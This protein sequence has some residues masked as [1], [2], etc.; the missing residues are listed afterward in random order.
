[1]PDVDVE[2]DAGDPVAETLTGR[3]HAMLSTALTRQHD[4]PFGNPVLAVALAIAREIEDGSI[5][6]ASIAEA[7]RVLRDD[8]FRRRAG[9]LAAYV[10]LRAGGDTDAG[11]ARFRR[12]AERCVRPDPHDSPVPLAR[13]REAV[14][15]IRFGAVFTA[16][17]TFAASPEVYAAL[18][19]LATGDRDDTPF[20]E[21]HRPGRI[22]L[23]EEFGQAFAAIERGR[24]AIDRLTTE[25]F[26][27]AAHVWPNS[28][29]EISPRP[30][31][32]T[33]W[34][35]YDTDG[36]TDIGWHDTLRLRLR[37]KRA[38]LERLSAQLEP[39]SGT[40]A[41][42]AR[43][44]AAIGAVSDQID[45]CPTGN[46][47][48]EV[49]RFA[50]ALVDRREEALLSPADLGPLL[51]DAEANAAP[52][53]V[54]PLLVA[55]AGLRS[56]GLSLSHTHMRLNATQI[57]NVARQRLGFTDAPED[58]SRR[59]ALLAQINEVLDETRPVPFDL[60][61]LIAE[62]AS[63]ARLMM[64]A[65]TI[66]KH[67]DQ[68]TP[69]RFLIAETES[70]YTLLCALWLAR[71]LGIERQIEISPLFETAEAL[72]RG[73]RVVDEAL[74][75]PHYQDYVRATGRL[76]LQF[77]YSDSGRYVGQMAAT[78]QI[79]RLR[80]KIA[81]L[82][83]TRGL[84]GIEV[85]LFDTHGESIGRGAH[86]G[87][88]ADR[89]AYLSPAW[90]RANFAR[91][92]VAIREE[93]AFQGGDGYALFG[94]PGLAVAT[95]ATIAE[96][97]FAA[98]ETGHDP[99]YEDP[100]FSADFFATIAGSMQA[101]VDDPG[102]AALLGAFGPALIDKTGSRPAARQSDGS[103]APVRIRHPSELR[104][105]PN[106]A[107][108]QQLGWCANTL[109]GLGAAAARHPEA[110]ERLSDDSPRFRRALDFARH[111]MAHSDRDVL[112]ATVVLLD[113]GTWLDRA[114]NARTAEARHEL[115][116]V[117]HGLKR[118]DLWASTQA[119]LHRI[120]DDSLLLADAWIDAPSMAPREMLLH[121]LRLALIER[122]WRL[123]ARIP[124]FAPR[125]G[126]TRDALEDQM[127][128]LD[129]PAALEQ[130][131]LIFPLATEEASLI[132]FREPSGPPTGG[133]YA[134]E[135]RVLFEPI[136]LLFGL[137]REVG[138]AIMHE[139][140]AFG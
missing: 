55:R 15:R 102:Y 20:F 92:Q 104:A 9:R 101:L 31:V 27:A 86:P 16:H 21:T 3:L 30:I 93:S 105:I 135:H 44:S 131:R 128:R 96:H 136:E 40:D 129:I 118:L 26:R 127:L 45:C 83:K 108:L 103:G 53:E 107:I 28:W 95:I 8:A 78:Y 68:T 113:P 74:R 79:E 51:A 120:E 134:A 80:L 10:G 5:E 122:I 130:L 94:T 60:G 48:T 99:I 114:A 61:T 32:L 25:L 140:G 132:D 126:L 66:I 49:A 33:S 42:R 29:R 89:L 59:R 117:A 14:E 111:A 109:Q 62:Q 56:H 36:R 73:V 119:M 35:G 116:H 124:Y 7:V 110:F 67:I 123:A 41:L 34:V 52:D 106:N 69:V 58:A 19:A 39:L 4:D 85:V 100:D 22:T 75:S 38:Q 13:F 97:A 23:E 11:T 6:E 50:R 57:H 115:V 71:L 121:A 47:P 65:G 46:D 64:V 70:G 1:M 90:T 24:D 91:A 98:I 37:M 137:V 87:S 12:V 138:T 84:D 72:E 133:A 88:L 112:R 17:P 63:A 77:G 18:V 43:L 81:D 139:V 2:L 125:G 82:L 76:C 54:L